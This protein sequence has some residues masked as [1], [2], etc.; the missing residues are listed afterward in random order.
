MIQKLTMKKKTVHLAYTYRPSHFLWC[1]VAHEIVNK[2]LYV[3]GYVYMC[4]HAPPKEDF[5]GIVGL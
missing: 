2:K 1:S 4:G 5:S 3:D